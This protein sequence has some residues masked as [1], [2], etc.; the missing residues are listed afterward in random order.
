MQKLSLICV[1]VFIAS[2]ILTSHIN[3]AKPRFQGPYIVNRWYMMPGYSDTP[4]TR[5]GGSGNIQNVEVIPCNND[6]TCQLKVGSNATFN[7]QFATTK[8]IKSLRAVVHGIVAGIPMPFH[9]PQPNACENSNVTCPIK[10]GDISHYSVQL[11]VLK[12][13]PRIKVTVKWELIDETGEDVIC[14]EV[15]ARLV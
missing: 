2:V 7:I 11:P 9:F 12:N 3:N 5:C 15:P 6:D 13:Y 8:E 4:F 10:S 14:L 1:G